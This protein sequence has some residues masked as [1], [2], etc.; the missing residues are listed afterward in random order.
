MKI[1]FVTMQ[2]NE[3]DL[4][5]CFIQHHAYLASYADIY[6]LDNGSDDQYTKSILQKYSNLGVNVHYEFASREDFNNKGAVVKKFIKDKELQNIYD[7]IFPV[8]CDEL[9]CLEGQ[10]CLIVNK[11]AIKSE[12]SDIFNLDKGRGFRIQHCFNNIPMTQNKFKKASQKKAFF[13]SQSDIIRLDTGYHLFGLD[14]E[15]TD[16]SFAYIHF[17]NRYY[18]GVLNSA[19]NKMVGR[20]DDFTNET[21]TLHRERKK[22][23]WHLVKYFLQDKEK[24]Y[25]EKTFID[26]SAGNIY[27]IDF[28]SHAK[29]LGVAYPFTDAQADKDEDIFWLK[30][31]SCLESIEERLKSEMALED[32]RTLAF[33]FGES[34]S[35]FAF[36]NVSFND[37]RGYG[38]EGNPIKHTRN[39]NMGNPVSD[40]FALAMKVN[41]IFKI[42]LPHSAYKI[43]IYTHDILFDNHSISISC[44]DEVVCTNVNTLKGEM[45]KIEFTV[46]NENSVIELF[47]SSEINNFI[48]NAMTVQQIPEYF[49]CKKVLRYA[50][51]EQYAKENSFSAQVLT[52]QNLE[53]EKLKNCIKEKIEYDDIDNACNYDYVIKNVVDYYRD[54]LS[55][56][57]AIVD[58]D[59]NKE[60]QYA[61][62]SFALACS[63]L[64]HIDNEYLSLSL[65]SL[66]LSIHNLAMR[67]CPNKH[68]DFFPYLIS[69]TLLNIK[70]HISI[71]RYETLV[72]SL[73]SINPYAV[74][75]SPI[76]GSDKSGQ[77]WN[78][79][80]SAGEV[81]LKSTI[82]KQD[83]AFIDNSLA[84]QSRHFDHE[85]GVYAEGP[86]IYDL[87]ARTL[88][89]DALLYYKGVFQKE[90]SSFLELGALNSLSIQSP[91]G[92]LIP[93]GRSG[94]HIWG[95]A[96]QCLLFE[97]YACHYSSMNE[98]ELSGI[99]HAGAKLSLDAICKNLNENGDLF[100][101]KNKFSSSMRQGYES[102]TSRS[103]YNLFAVSLLSVAKSNMYDIDFSK[104]SKNIKPLPKV[105]NRFL[106]LSEST[107]R[108]VATYNGNQIVLDLGKNLKQN[109]S[110]I[111]RCMLNDGSGL[112][113]GSVSKSSFNQLEPSAFTS[114]S[115]YYMLN[116]ERFNLAENGFNK[117][118]K[119]S[120][121]E[122][123]LDNKLI[124]SVKY[125]ITNEDVIFNTITIGVD[126]IEVSFK[127]FS[128][129]DIEKITFPFLSSDGKE[130]YA[131][132]VAN[133]IVTINDHMGCYHV[134]F[135]HESLAVSNAEFSNKNGLVK[136]ISANAV[137]NFAS[138]KIKK[139]FL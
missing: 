9:F 107:G 1:T 130:S 15:L 109:A 45:T 77:N 42:K 127:A 87:K 73:N 48:I 18:Q 121:D 25:K 82:N 11:D 26:E 101:T 68:E 93:G 62:P 46:K 78:M 24:Y 12:L 17:H 47:F 13:S 75:R 35:G 33:S 56:D 52:A 125:Y 55:S 23:G 72:S 89:S 90:M 14:A 50:L 123:F 98:Y 39:R 136:V 85:K 119:I 8:D 22:P 92:Y 37:D 115:I 28:D 54:Y 103:H 88:W 29:H 139:G 131:Y 5:E 120:V 114:A 117:F 97:I 80:A 102:Y 124:V 7:F 111:I 2:K 128:G 61:T 59:L 43:C 132:S 110:G 122:K 108:V 84:L 133:D 31:P 71:S 83:Y 138:L 49:E 76:G 44:N 41:K 60:H 94:N 30:S 65:K 64:I 63:S 4:L 40:S 10:N 16:T 36:G 27:F 19:R 6:I 58:P 113:E 81:I 118:K 95:E 74:Y 34:I 91:N 57:G 106:N 79:L 134:E 70:D 96:L 38:W 3:K 100:V 69:K 129:I 137:D 112:I 116:G 32:E 53:I 99:F 104:V 126:D 51:K 67:D 135:N 105:V 86:I 66:E 21:L 20:V